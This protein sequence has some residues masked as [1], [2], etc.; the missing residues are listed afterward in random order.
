[1]AKH[2]KTWAWILGLLLFIYAITALILHL[3]PVGMIYFGQSLISCH[4]QLQY[5]DLAKRVLVAENDWKEG[6]EIPASV[7]LDY[8]GGRLPRCPGGGVYT[9]GNVGALPACSFAGTKGPAPRK[10]LVLIFGWRWEVP[11]SGSHDL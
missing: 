8:F 2:T 3:P 4:N 10:K 7:L 11:P 9:Y 1:V 6:D 5:I